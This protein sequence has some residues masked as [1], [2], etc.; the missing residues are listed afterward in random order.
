MQAMILAAGFGTRLRPYSLLKPKPLFPVLNKPLLLATIDRLKN[1]GFSRIIVNCHHLREQVVQAVGSLSGVI[2]QEEEQI[3]GTGGGLREACS[4]VNDDPLLVTNGDIYHT[5]DFAE[6]Y[7]YHSQSSNMV[8]MALHDFPRFNNVV[9]EGDRVRGFVDSNSTSSKLAFSGI[10]VIN[11][12]IL[13]EIEPGKQSCI[14]EHYRSLLTKKIPIHFLKYDN[15]HWTDMGTPRD[16]LELHHSLLTGLTPCWP[17]LEYGGDT[18]LIDSEADHSTHA[19]MKD[20][21][22][23][24]KA[25]IEPGALLSRCVVWDGAVVKKGSVFSDAIVIP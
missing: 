11:P 8:T 14:I 10:Q 12:S 3:L 22:C 20:W 21:A 1:S 17:E 4:N 5:I 23:V 13:R 6:L 18:F 16:Y 25:R 15:A 9:I 19:E 2:V 24:G 7:K